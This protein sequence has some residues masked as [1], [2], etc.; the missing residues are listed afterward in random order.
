MRTIWT[1]LVDYQMPDR[2]MRRKNYIMSDTM[3]IASLERHLKNV[4]GKILHRVV[5][6][7]MTFDEV[8]ED[9]DGEMYRL[10][11]LA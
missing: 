5:M 6:P 3:Q 2:T 10:E 8:M 1:I 9:I 4:N 7:I 11:M